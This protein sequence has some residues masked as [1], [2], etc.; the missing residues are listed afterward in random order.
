[1]RKTRIK[2]LPL[3]AAICLL[4]SLMQPAAAAQEREITITTVAD[5]LELAQR[6]SLDT[7]SQGKTVR[8]EADLDLTGTA[9]TPIP[10]FGG[11]FDGQGHTISG[12][13]LTSS[14]S[15]QGLFRTIQ[16]NGVVENLTVSGTVAPGGS[17]TSVGGI[18][19]VNSGIIRSCSFSGSVSGKTAVGGIVGRN[20]ESGQIADCFVS[21][22]IQG[23]SSTGGVAGRNLGVLLKCSSSASVNTSEE[24]SSVP[25]VE[26][27]ADLDLESTL[28]GAE[29]DEAESLLDSC[30]DTGGIAGYS[31]GVIQSCTNSGTVGYPHVGYNVG[32]IAGRQTGYLAGCVNKGSVLGR[33]DVGG[34][35]GQAEPDLTVNPSSD[36]LERL[37]TELD[38]LD[39]LIQQAINDAQSSSDTVSAH[40]TAIGDYT[41]EARDHTKT[42]ADLSADFIDDGMDSLNSLSAS[43]TNALDQ[44]APALDDLAA[45]SDK[46]EEMSGDLDETLEGLTDALEDGEDIRVDVKNAA[47]ALRASAADMAQASQ[48]LREILDTLLQGVVNDR[49]SDT[50]TALEDLSRE[51]DRLSQAVEGTGTAVGTLGDAL[52]GQPDLPGGQETLTALNTLSDALTAAGEDLGDASQAIPAS[53]VDWDTLKA[54][55][56]TMGQA[57]Y[58]ASGHFENAVKALQTAVS[59]GHALTEDLREVLDALSDVVDTGE[60]IGRKLSSAFRTMGDAVTELAEDGPVEFPVLGEDVRTAGDDLFDSLG[61]IS[62]E[63]EALHTAM[64]TAGDT[65]TADLRSISSQFQTVF[66]VLLDALTDLQDGMDKSLED[67]IEDTSEEDIAATRQ[68]KVTQCQN[69]GSVEG[70]R[71]VGGIAGAMAIEFDLDPEDDLADDL[72]FGSSYETKAVLEDS[73]NRG[74]VTAKKDCAG[75]L[76]GRMDLGTVVSGQNY[77]PVTSTDGN[78]VGGIAGWADASVRDSCAKCALSG[79]DYVGGIAGWGDRLLDNCT[80]ATVEEG[81]E[82][83]GAVAGDADLDKGTVRGNR[84]VDTGL[85]AIDGVSY[86]GKAAPV[87]FA[88][89]RQEQG[90]PTEFISFTLTLKAGE[91]VV[92]QIPFQYGEDLR[93]VELPEVPE[94]EGCYG[95]WPEF[96]TSGLA[97]DITLEAVY[98]PWVTVVA[99]PQ[100]EGKL[101]LAM[102]DGQFTQDAAL[103][104]RQSDQAPPQEVQDKDTVRVWELSLTGTD[105]TEQDTVSLRLLSSGGGCASVWQ[106]RDGAWHKVDTKQNGHYL[107][108]DMEGTSGTFCV[109]SSPH[110]GAVLLLAVAA[111]LLVALVVILA[112]RRKRQKKLVV[113]KQAEQPPQPEEASAGK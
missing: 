51:M 58:Q 15:K 103:T 70:D 19:G 110:S 6:C 3:L 31:S 42:L 17:Q 43:V 13:S 66:D 67:Y 99:S 53:G 16:S 68:G 55:L 7:W 111:V 94:Q 25:S 74:T 97:S 8:L 18:A 64:D 37:R 9:F 27:L 28:T 109:S 34:I 83:L 12:L 72:S 46:L 91:D 84:F 32:G 73:V 4:F 21:G 54:A 102:A 50:E 101:A 40:L 100:Q 89:L 92:A 95:A 33:K 108:L 23:E 5:L 65:L 71:N 82:Y 107:L 41:D 48:A 56:E 112:V 52:A 61:E 104:V 90:I 113:S 1:M 30:T 24:G 10:T 35:V 47:E 78:Y 76:V 62:S 60:G 59:D 88:A 22:I 20:K 49:P 96:D 36:T 80:I 11:T 98:T 106:Y 57:L 2:L 85:A 81:T 86:A 26:D 38:T 45:A 44:V 14:G 63:M 69:T 77:G 105:L 93:L 75:G 79:G 39:G 29:S 87:E